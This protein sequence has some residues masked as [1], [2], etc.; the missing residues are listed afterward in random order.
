[1]KQNI[2]I[3][4]CIWILVIGLLTLS[5]KLHQLP[6]L[7][8]VPLFGGAAIGGGVAFLITNK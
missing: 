3:V 5:L 7:P 2:L 1:M 4:V 6:L 8:W